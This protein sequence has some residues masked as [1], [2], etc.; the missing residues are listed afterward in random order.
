MKKIPKFYEYKIDWVVI[1]PEMKATIFS[2]P[3]KYRQYNELGRSCNYSPEYFAQ[4]FRS[5]PD[6]LNRVVYNAIVDYLGV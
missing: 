1:T 5:P 4:I 6:K 2:K 3:L